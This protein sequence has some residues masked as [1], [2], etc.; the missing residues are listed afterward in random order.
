MALET[1]LYASAQ[2]QIRKAV[3]LLGITSKTSEIA[4]LIIGENSKEIESALQ[5]ISVHINAQHDDAVLELSEDKNKIIQKTFG[6]SGL[7]LRTVMKNDDVKN[8][9]TDLVIERMALLATQH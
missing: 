3:T 1:I 2:R 7:E 6:I 5:M 9:L 8:A 4:V